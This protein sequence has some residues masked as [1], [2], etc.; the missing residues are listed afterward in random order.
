[1]RNDSVS[2]TQGQ[3]RQIA[4]T[5]RIPPPMLTAHSVCLWLEGENDRLKINAYC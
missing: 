1:M 4:P 3:M 2:T 5:P